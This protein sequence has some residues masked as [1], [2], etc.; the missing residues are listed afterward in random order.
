MGKMNLPNHLLLALTAIAIWNVSPTNASAN[1]LHFLSSEYREAVKSFERA[2]LRADGIDRDRER[3]VDDLEDATTPLRTWSRSRNHAD[4]FLESWHT[5]QLL[6]VEVEAVIFRRLARAD[7]L[8]LATAWRR[9]NFAFG[10]LAEEIRVCAY[11]HPPVPA[12]PVVNYPTNYAPS[13][14]PPAYYQ[15]PQYYLYD[16]PDCYRGGFPLGQVGHGDHHHRGRHHEE[17]VVNPPVSHDRTY[18]FSIPLQ[19]E[20]RRATEQASS[21]SILDRRPSIQYQTRDSSHSGLARQGPV[22]QGPVQQG[23]AQQIKFEQRSV[24][25]RVKVGANLSR[26][27]LNRN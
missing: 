3:L 18:T 26:T 20:V 13:Y 11:L 12:A 4:R 8:P 25:S 2:V 23:P 1:S 27:N 22:R 6:H 16:I 5:V 9:A 14:N 10:R 24:G 15:T 7:R 21:R 17:A 19:K